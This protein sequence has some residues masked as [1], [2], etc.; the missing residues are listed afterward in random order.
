M[1]CKVLLGAACAALV[2]GV[3]AGADLKS[4]PEPGKSVP[5]FHPLSVTGKFAG[6]TQCLV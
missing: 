3:G 1:Y 6:K 5:V 2:C 4:G